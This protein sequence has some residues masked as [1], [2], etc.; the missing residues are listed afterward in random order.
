VIQVI[1][2]AVTGVVGGASLLLLVP[3]VNS[4]VDPQAK[5]SLPVLGSISLGGVPLA[6]LLGIF[7][8][9][10]TILA[11]LTMYQAMSSTVLQ[12]TLVDELRREAFEAVLSARW[13][14]VLGQRRSDIIEV[15]TVGASRSGFAYQQL[16]RLA[17]NVVLLLGT[18]VITVLVSPMVGAIALVGVLLLGLAQSTSIRPAYRMGAVFGER[19]RQLQAVMTNS[20]DALR[21][22]RAHNASE[23]WTDKLAAAFAD[24]REVQ[25]ANVKRTSRVSATS[26]IGL[27]AAAAVLVLICVYT[28]L[29]P[30]SIAVLLVL[31]ARLARL[32]QSSV[33]TGALLSNSL[34][35]VGDVTGLTLEARANREAPAGVGT[36]RPNIDHFSNANLLEFRDVSFCYPDSN[37]G[38]Q[39][40]SFAVPRGLITVL[41]GHSG[42]GKS[43]VAD[44]ALGLISPDEGEIQVDGQPLEVADLQWWRQHVAYVPQETGMIS[45]TLRENLV[46]STTRNV[47]D[48]DCW[49]ALD[50]AAATFA[51]ALPNGLDTV[52]GDRGVRV[53]G[54][55]RQRIAIAR[56]LLRQPALLVLDEATSALDD[57]TESSVLKV[58]TSLVPAVTLLVIAHRRS[59]VD[60]AH[61]CVRLAGGRVA[62]SP[63]AARVPDIS[64]T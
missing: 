5:V 7:V 35:A 49:R 2:L 30:A 53:S 56:A 41:T 25:I 15:V 33:D 39:E 29:P 40:L 45:A 26:Q 19:N 46:W 9:L 42:A 50:Q 27:A 3:I 64:R 51:R 37:N 14:F 43:T 62:D 32:V 47:S 48:D 60:S 1:L 18:A 31:V 21:L 24:T 61:H 28:N 36:R 63:I 11:L 44:L 38:V 58:L 12:Q 20:L 55:E 22:V 57:E 54:G 52:L 8:A 17:V 59:T 16:L 23:V 6:L 34:T 4:V 13:T 10:T